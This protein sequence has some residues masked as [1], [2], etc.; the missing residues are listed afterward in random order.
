MAALDWFRPPRS[1]L[2]LYLA[3]AGVAL[4]C[5]AWLSISQLNSDELAEAQRTQQ[6]LDGAAARVAAA[7][8]QG[9]DGLRLAGV[10]RSSEL[11]D[12]TVVIRRTNGMTEVLRGTLVFMPEPPAST[13]T[14]FEALARAEAL[15]FGARDFMRAAEAYRELTGRSTRAVA[16]HALVGLARVLRASVRQA[17]ALAEYERLALLT[18][19][20]IEGRPADLVAR[21]GR[22]RA[23]ND[24]GQLTTLQQEAELLRADLAR[25]KWPLSGG[26]WQATF[27]DA[28][29]WAGAG[30][31]AIDGLGS[32]LALA[33]AFTQYI[34]RRRDGMAAVPTIV[35]A[36]GG[37]AVIVPGPGD[38]DSLSLVVGADWLVSLWSTA[39]STA[40][41]NVA[42][43]DRDD[44]VLLGRK[45]GR[46][47]RRAPADTGFPWAV[48]VSDADPSRAH[49]DGVARRRTLMIG[50]TVVGLLIVGSGYFT[51]RGIRRELATARMHAEFVSAASHE[52]RT[53]LTSIRQLSHMLQSGRVEDDRRR[54]EYYGVLV[55]ETE[56][57]HR[58]VDRL[59]K[60][61]R[62]DAGQF[63]LET[64]DA[65][66]LAEYVANDFRRTAGD[67]AFELST[68]DRPCPFRVDRELVTLAVWNLLENAVKYSPDGGAVRLDVRATSGHVRMTVTDTGIGIPAQD[69]RRIFEQF[70]RGSGAAAWGATGS[71]LGLALVDRVV[72]AH[73]GEVELDSVPGRGSIFTIVLPMEAGA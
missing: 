32:R 9:L 18:D 67:R 30:A 46:D 66:E 26:A 68:S 43:L 16:A 19:I 35:T 8:R 45:S 14:P 69:Q 58:L 33:D 13:E 31:A 1:V 21:I 64:V 63:Q 24:L 12:G 61:G 50:L 53:P 3:G 37:R 65:R 44:Q 59:L 54:D 11:P 41:V 42:L 22:C 27:N 34:E 72:R 38:A 10:N 71:G 17:E 56:R 36:E 2:T 47:V 40:A 57:L 49:A 73:G 6:R 60:F 25:G 28:T 62:V 20:V 15:E 29:G 55:R 4:A 51:F 70:V 48:A 39:A 52:L 7:V 23:L 5:F